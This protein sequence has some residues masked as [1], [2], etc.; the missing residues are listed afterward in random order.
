MFI[1]A[2]SDL[3]LWLHLGCS[4]Q[5]K[6]LPQPISL[7]IQIEFNSC[8]EG[9]QDDNLDGV[10]CYAVLTKKIKE[11]CEIRR[12]NLIENVAASVHS[13]ISKVVVDA[14]ITVKATKIKS[15]VESIHG[16]VSF[17]YSK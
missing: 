12:F 2:I 10:I 9:V 16:G 11:F 17:T 3:R 8:P 1:L 14:K 6:F 15:P 7:D 13:I 5:E 4:E